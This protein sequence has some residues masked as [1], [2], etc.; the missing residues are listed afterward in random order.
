MSIIG[1]SAYAALFWTQSSYANF[2]LQFVFL[3]QSIYGWYFWN[4]KENTRK[5]TRTHPSQALLLL[6]LSFALEIMAF[7]AITHFTKTPETNILMDSASATLSIIALYLMSRKVLEHWLLWVI[8]DV[9]FIA[10]FIHLGLYLSSM[11]YVLF[12]ILSINGY[13]SWRRISAAP[14]TQTIAAQ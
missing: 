5:I 14:P 8:A 6:L 13:R 1:V 11:L 4:K 2:T 7:L 10:Y 3:G 9:V 12:F